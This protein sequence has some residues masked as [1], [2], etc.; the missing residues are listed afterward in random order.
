MQGFGI[1]LNRY[2]KETRKALTTGDVLVVRKIT[3]M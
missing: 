3:R 2:W 1:P